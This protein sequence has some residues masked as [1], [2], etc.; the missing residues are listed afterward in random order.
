MARTR[1][2][3]RLE[4]KSKQS[5]LL[6]TIGIIVVF[7]LL[8]KF[9]IPMLANFSLFISQI[10]KKEDVGK[11]ESTSYVAPPILNPLPNAT[12]SASIVISGRAF[13]DQSIS[14][15][16]NDQLISKQSTDNKGEFSFRE[17]LDKGSNSI[18][19]KA[20]QQNNESD[21]SDTFNV[22]YE[23]KSPQLSIDSPTDGQSFSKTDNKALVSGKT[24]SGVDVTING[25]WAIMDEN[26]QYSYSLTLKNGENQISVTA[27]DQAGNK[28]EKTIRVNYSQ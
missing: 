8:F 22:T 23:D 5:F 28:T 18:K 24:D 3:R 11:T 20:K 14:L 16:I 1:L 15:F 7:F 17:S 13:K 4:K 12:N 6:T 27:T 2:S 19:T 21:F 10:G 26:N 9:G 25:F